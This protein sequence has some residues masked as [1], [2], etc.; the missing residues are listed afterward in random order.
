MACQPE[1]LAVV[2]W[3]IVIIN[4][5]NGRPADGSFSIFAVRE[6]LIRRYS[7]CICF[8]RVWCRHLRNALLLLLLLSFW[9]VAKGGGGG[10]CLG[11]SDPSTAIGR[12][13]VNHNNDN[14]ASLSQTAQ[15]AP[16][17]EALT[18]SAHALVSFYR[19]VPK[20]GGNA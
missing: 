4:N 17:A 16:S 11:Y 13:P 15:R 9:A 12:A 6:H 3:D 2:G 7:S 19:P 5:N 1:S 14:S 18:G 10:G 8:Y 20:P